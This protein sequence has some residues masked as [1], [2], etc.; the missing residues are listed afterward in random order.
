MEELLHK[1]WLRET[2]L[3]RKY[4]YY[5]YCNGLRLS[6]KVFPCDQ[7]PKGIDAKTAKQIKSRIYKI[8]WAYEI[9]VFELRLKWM[10]MILAVF[11]VHLRSS[12]KGWKIQARTGT[13]TAV[14]MYERFQN[15]LWL[16]IHHLRPYDRSISRSVPSW[17][18]SSTG[19]ALHRHWRV[20][21]SSFCY[22][23]KFSDPS[24]YSLGRSQRKCENL[25]CTKN[26]I[27]KNK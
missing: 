26:M 7:L 5:I 3:Y 17:L 4:W 9:H 10:H 14:Q 19:G 20:Q 6:F 18:D 12:E 8:I 16:H 25:T 22:R 24:R 1:S 2:F 13:R 21:G 11:L 23:L 15:H 27:T